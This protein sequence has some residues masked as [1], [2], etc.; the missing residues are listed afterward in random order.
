M[1]AISKKA[2]PFA[3]GRAPIPK[4]MPKVTVGGNS[5]TATITPTNTDDT[6]VVIESAAAAPDAKAKAKPSIPTLVRESNSV[7]YTRSG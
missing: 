1:L 5:A 6:P 3:S 7:V 4:Q 2:A